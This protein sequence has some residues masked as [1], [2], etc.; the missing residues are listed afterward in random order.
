MIIGKNTIKKK[1]DN[2]LSPI[3]IYKGSVHLKYVVEI[4]WLLTECWYTWYYSVR[5]KQP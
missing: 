2:M 1:D 3:K 4:K 5:A